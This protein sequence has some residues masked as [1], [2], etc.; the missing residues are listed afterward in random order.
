[1]EEFRRVAAFNRLCGVDVKEIGARDVRTLFPLCKVDDVEA[2]FYV[3]DDGR[4][5]VKRT[6]L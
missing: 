2:G 5:N 4:V 1:M 3:E 6:A